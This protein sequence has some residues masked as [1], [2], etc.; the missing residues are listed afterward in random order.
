MKLPE[1]IKK[2]YVVCDAQDSKTCLECPFF[3]LPE[4]RFVCRD[5]EADIIEE[6]RAAI[7]K[8]PCAEIIEVNEMLGDI[9]DDLKYLAKLV[10]NRIEYARKGETTNDEETT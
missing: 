8:C 7:P 3:H 6:L 1:T 4:S 5:E 2:I 10:K 9:I